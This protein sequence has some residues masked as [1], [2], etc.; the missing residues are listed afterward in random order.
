MEISGWVAVRCV[1]RSRA[2]DSGEAVYEERVTLWRETDVDQAIERAEA[3]A[4]T[5]A[6]ETTWAPERVTE[7]LGLAQAYS[8]SD[9]PT[10]GA[11]VFSLMRTSGL[12]PTAYLDRF[13]HTGDE[14]QR[15]VG[16]AGEP[17]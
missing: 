2:E 10:D 9:E 14:R 6:T 11:E 8:L 5:Y 4:R 13:F 3:E 1:F 16:D 12:P 17:V 15:H 7:Y